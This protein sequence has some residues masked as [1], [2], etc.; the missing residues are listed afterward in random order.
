MVVE[1]LESV[2][3]HG[4]DRESGVVPDLHEDVKSSWASLLDVVW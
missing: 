3:L 1:S 4:T 2:T